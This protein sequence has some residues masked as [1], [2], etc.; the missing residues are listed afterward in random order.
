MG[1]REDVVWFG[2]GV[3][4]KEI[5]QVFNDLS[6]YLTIKKKKQIKQLK[7]DSNFFWIKRS[8]PPTNA[9]FALPPAK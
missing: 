7:Y 8:L 3:I 1:L 4:K 5:K 6:F 9:S 2:N